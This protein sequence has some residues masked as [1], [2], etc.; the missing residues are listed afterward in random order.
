MTQPGITQ[1]GTFEQALV[2]VE[3][4]AEVAVKV[5][6]AV[7]RELK[8]AKAA[9]ATGS[10]R[11]LRRA[12]AAA[13]GQSAELAERATALRAE[14][15]VDESALLASGDYTKELI[16]AAEE[17]GVGVY[18]EDDRLLCYPSVI[19]LLPAEL[20][21]DI[22]RRRERRLRPSVLVGLLARAQGAGPKFRPEPLLE[23]LSAAYDLVVAAQGKQPGAVVRLVDVHAVL[24]LLPGQSRDYGKQEFAR[25]LYLLDQSGVATTKAGRRLRWSAS[26]GT[27][28]AGVLTTV[29]RSG[30]QQRYWG[31]AFQP[32]ERAS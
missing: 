23:S 8:R 12:L 1:Q 10:I 19:R 27:R 22:D 4:D 16:A 21:L 25:D 7:T 29:A 6:A 14:Y 18:E 31:V 17:A 13:E 2:A 28:G 9:A 11:D 30:Q 3:A 5:A 15:D 24:T 20:A 32:P 26:T